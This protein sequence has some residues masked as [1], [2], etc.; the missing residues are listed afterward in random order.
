M[1]SLRG[2]GP[3][4]A[5]AIMVASSSPVRA[6]GV[7]Q[8]CCHRCRAQASYPPPV[9]A[10]APPPG[11]T[12]TVRFRRR[13]GPIRRLLGRCCRVPVYACPPACAPAPYCPAPVIVSPPVAL[14]PGSVYYAPPPPPSFRVTPPAAPGPNGPPP[15]PPTTGSYYPPERPVAPVYPQRLT[16]AKPTKPVR[17]DLIVSRRKG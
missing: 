17:L 6:D 8:K 5:L 16:P 4:C 12:V 2:A 14:P 3:A 13:C 9:C 7:F 1:R 11:P 10:Y 15:A